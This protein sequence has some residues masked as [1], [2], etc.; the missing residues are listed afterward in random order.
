MRICEAERADNVAAW[1][2]DLWSWKSW[3]CCSKPILL[4]G[5]W[6]VV[7]KQRAT[8]NGVPSDWTA[9]QILGPSTNDL[10]LGHS[11]KVSKLADDT[12]L[13]TDAPD[14]KS[15]RIWQMPFNLDKCHV[16]HMGI[17]NQADNYSLLGSTTSS[18]N[19][20][21]GHRDDHYGGPQDLCTMYSSV[22]N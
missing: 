12:N 1:P 17:P 14:P 18:V 20:K 7:R 4:P 15:V 9:G 5:I 8:L 6:L 16:M 22:A 3:Q 19:Q 21:K 2:Q 13:W 11:S 10:D